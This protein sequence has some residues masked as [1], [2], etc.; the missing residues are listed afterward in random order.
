MLL[1]RRL[2]L[3]R[4]RLGLRLLPVRVTAVPPLLVKLSRMELPL[5]FKL[6]LLPRRRWR[7]RLRLPV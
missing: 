6:L 2:L 3:L 1:L 4:L 7:R 5:L